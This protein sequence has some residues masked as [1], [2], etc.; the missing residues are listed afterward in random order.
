MDRNG[1]VPSVKKVACVQFQVEFFHNV[2]RFSP[3]IIR[4]GLRGPINPRY[5]N[6]DSDVIHKMDRT[7]IL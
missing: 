2:D 1:N 4:D 6:E 3:E 7:I 5:L